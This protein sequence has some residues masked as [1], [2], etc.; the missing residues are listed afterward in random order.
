MKKILTEFKAF[1]LKGNV[2]DLAVAVVI[3]GAFGKIVSAIVSDIIMPLVGAITPD[4]DWRKAAWGPT[5]KVQFAYG[6]LIGEIVDFTI[7]AFVIFLV[8]VK[9][10]GAL[11]KKP[12]T[13]PATTKTCPECL[14]TIAIKARKCKFCTSTQPETA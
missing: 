11:K 14:E 7:V 1:A 6:H 13:G 3:G 2:I 5:D 10:M 12:E 4:G 9:M 8:V